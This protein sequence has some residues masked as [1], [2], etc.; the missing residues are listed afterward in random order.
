MN[1]KTCTTPLS[2]ALARVAA[3]SAGTGAGTVG[4]P[5]SGGQ[6]LVKEVLPAGSLEA[7]AS[8]RKLREQL[9]EVRSTVAHAKAQV[10]AADSVPKA[11]VCNCLTR[12]SM[13]FGLLISLVV[14]SLH[15]DAI[16]TLSGSLGRSCITRLTEYESAA[17]PLHSILNI[18][19]QAFSWRWHVSVRAKELWG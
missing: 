9:E 5:G 19:Q 1:S 7:F 17:G 8:N 18:V 12:L 10:A 3:S 15:C 11:Q 16:S 4:G 14:P 13:G 6:A 2:N